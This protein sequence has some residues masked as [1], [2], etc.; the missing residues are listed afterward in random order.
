MILLAGIL[1]VFFGTFVTAMSV[2]LVV[3]WVVFA[4][5]TL[6]FFRDPS[7]PHAGRGQARGFPGPRE[8]RCH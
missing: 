3:V 7:A 2:V 4:V 8:G 6:Y 1:A 5:F